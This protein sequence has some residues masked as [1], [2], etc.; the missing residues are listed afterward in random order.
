MNGRAACHPGLV[1]RSRALP[2]RTRTS[3]SRSLRNSSTLIKAGLVKDGQQIAECARAVRVV[4]AICLGNLFP[5]PGQV[6]HPQG[7]SVLPDPP[8]ADL[9]GQ[10]LAN[11]RPRA[12]CIA[13]AART[14][15]RCHQQRGRGGRYPGAPM[16]AISAA[17]LRSPAARSPRWPSITAT[18]SSSV[19]SMKR[20]GHPRTCMN[21]GR[22]ISVMRHKSGASG[23][24][25]DLHPSL[26]GRPEGRWPRRSPGRESLRCD[27]AGQCELRGEGVDRPGIACR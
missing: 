12:W 11:G 2:G 14:S 22:S 27:L 7:G 13:T 24:R 20:P 17:C 16:N 8:Q 10:R 6:Q 19:V 5:L 25:R 1:R 21:P 15:Q 4:L 18:I 23:Q 9:A 3:G 26:R